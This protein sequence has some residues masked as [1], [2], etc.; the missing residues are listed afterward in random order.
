MVFENFQIL[1]KE[2]IRRSKSDDNGIRAVEVSPLMSLLYYAK[3]GIILENQEEKKLLKILGEVGG[4]VYQRR[5][6]DRRYQ[7]DNF[8]EISHIKDLANACPELLKKEPF[9]FDLMKNINSRVNYKLTAQYSNEY[10]DVAEKIQSITNFLMNNEDADTDLRQFAETT[11]AF[12]DLLLKETPEIYE[13]E[14][15]YQIYENLR[16]NYTFLTSLVQSRLVSKRHGIRVSHISPLYNMSELIVKIS[17][18][19]NDEKEL[20]NMIAGV[21]FFITQEKVKNPDYIFDNENDM[22]RIS[23]LLNLC[24]E[25]AR[26]ITI[27]EMVEEIKNSMVKIEPSKTIVK[28]VK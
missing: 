21:G 16:L 12:Y 17:S 13:V 4:Y 6:T 18:Y 10:C 19:N 3:D 15:K 26:N 11:Q 9:I 2:I 14:T 5:V 23:E 24:P 7:Y 22:R 27:Q 8:Y 28:T 1:A 25:L 20:V